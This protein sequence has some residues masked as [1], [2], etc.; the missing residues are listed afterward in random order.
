MEKIQTGCEMRF[1]FFIDKKMKSVHYL[2]EA[3]EIPA[4]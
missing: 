4:S 3:I 2:F 1:K